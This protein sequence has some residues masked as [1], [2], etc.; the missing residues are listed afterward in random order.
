MDR[1]RLSLVA[2]VPEDDGRRLLAL[3]N[4]SAYLRCLIESEPESGRGSVHPENS[5]QPTAEV[6]RRRTHSASRLVPRESVAR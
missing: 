3:A 6:I 1:G 5:V 4:S 2:N